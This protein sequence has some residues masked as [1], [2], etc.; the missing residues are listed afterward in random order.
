MKNEKINNKQEE[1]WVYKQQTY[2][3]NLNGIGASCFH[4]KC[5]SQ[6][7]IDH[8]L[9]LFFC[10]AVFF[11][12]FTRIIRLRFHQVILS[13]KNIHRTLHGS[14]SS[15]YPISLMT[16]YLHILKNSPVFWLG[17]VWGSQNA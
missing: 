6:H 14:V 8:V 17:S 10:V 9:V 3:V 7:G 1:Q 2:T 4:F 11:V 15:M 13:L 16:D 5:F 12:F